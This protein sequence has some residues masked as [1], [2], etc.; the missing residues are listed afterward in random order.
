M[1]NKIRVTAWNEFRHEKS[2]DYVKSI[3]PDGIHG[4]I[5]KF[6]ET[7][8]DI[9]VTLASL[10]DPDNGLPDE[11]LNNTDVLIWWGH[12]AHHEVPDA[13]VERIRHRVYTKGM[14]LIVLHSGHHSK[15][16]RQV[17]GTNGNLSWG[18]DQ[19]EIVWN[20]LPSH[21]IAA[22]IPDHFVL[23]TEE[24]YCEPFYVPQPDALVFGS[25]FEDGFIFRSGLCYLR[26]AGKVF[27]FQPGHESCPSY[28]NEYVQ[29]IITNAVYWAKPACF[30]YEIPEGAPMMEYK[31]IDEFKS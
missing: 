17:V 25:W 5:K 21:P 13:L 9:E 22:G 29:K 31:P 15:V 6:L 30:G 3:Y 20:L 14:G 11:V 26:G 2:N 8:D 28:H 12:M 19:K 1:A 4:L 7:K 27:Y 18:R 10:D 23:E 24:L 16:F